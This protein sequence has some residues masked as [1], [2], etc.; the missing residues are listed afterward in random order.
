MSFSS[1]SLAS[2]SNCNNQH[3]YAKL[4][5]HKLTGSQQLQIYNPKSNYFYLATYNTECLLQNTD[6]VMQ[7][8]EKLRLKT[9]HCRPALVVQTCSGVSHSQQCAWPVWP[10]GSGGL[11]QAPAACRYMQ[12]N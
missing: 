11:L 4:S 8:K 5:Q 3:Y 1:L 6:T 7:L 2:Q 9:L 10:P 12:V